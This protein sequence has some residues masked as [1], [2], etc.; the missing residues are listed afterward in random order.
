MGSSLGNFFGARRDRVMDGET[1]TRYPIKDY[2]RFEYDFL[3]Q[4]DNP[5]TLQ[6][7]WMASFYHF[8]LAV[9]KSGVNT[10]RSWFW[11]RVKQF[12]NDFVQEE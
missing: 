7:I 4:G 1:R 12:I 11:L 9:E 5:T 2:E 6:R 8:F 10:G 3:Y